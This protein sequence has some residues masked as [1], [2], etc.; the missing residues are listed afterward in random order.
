MGHTITTWLRE[1]DLELY[2][3]AATNPELEEE[4]LKQNSLINYLYNKALRS[5]VYIFCLSV[6]VSVCLFVYN[7]R[8]N[9]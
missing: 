4:L 5:S 6:W 1:C 8:Q 9:G 3:D 2:L 7:K